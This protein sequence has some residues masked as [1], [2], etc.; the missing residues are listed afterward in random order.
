MEIIIPSGAQIDR[1]GF[2]C[3]MCDAPFWTLPALESHVIK[4]SEDHASELAVA[5]A[6][7]RDFYGTVD[8]EWEQYNESLRRQGLDPEVQYARGRKSD[9]R[10][11]SES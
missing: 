5:Q 1:P 3:R 6:W 10:R 9:I 11:A 4:C 8:P 2:Q 7:W